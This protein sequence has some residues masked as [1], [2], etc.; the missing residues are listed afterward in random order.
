M[1]PLAA[2]RHVLLCDWLRAEGGAPGCVMRERGMKAY[3]RAR[4]SP[5][6]EA[7]AAADSYIRQSETDG[8]SC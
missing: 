6:L 8:A 5:T 3:G 7:G 1:L 4:G 2:R